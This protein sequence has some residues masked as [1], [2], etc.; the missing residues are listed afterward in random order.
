[1]SRK[2]SHEEME[3]LRERFVSGAV[4]NGVPEDQAHQVYDR[5]S[6]FSGFGFNRAHAASFALLSYFSAW[7]KLYHP[8]PFFVGL[9]NNQPMGFYSPSVV[10]EDAK[11]HGIREPVGGT[12]R[13]RGWSYPAGA[14]LRARVRPRGVQGG[15]SGPREQA[16]HRARGSGQAN[17]IGPGGTGGAH[18]GRRL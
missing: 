14:Q 6:A 17:G 11:R 4:A 1:M 9:L 2:R 10:V 12:V 16:L 18:H 7:L 13:D 8:V 3:A 5:L 15:S